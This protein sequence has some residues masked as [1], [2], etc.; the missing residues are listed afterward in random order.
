MATDADLLNSR[1]QFSA[2]AFT[3]AKVVAQCRPKSSE[4]TAARER[5][6]AG[7]GVRMLCVVSVACT[8][9]AGLA[10]APECSHLRP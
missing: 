5:A 1:E 8:E 7:H 6:A 3:F 2:P 4:E 9:T 10:A